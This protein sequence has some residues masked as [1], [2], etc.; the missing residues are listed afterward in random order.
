MLFG[1]YAKSAAEAEYPELWNGLVLSSSPCTAP[2]GGLAVQ[3][4]V[5]RR[6]GTFLNITESR[7]NSVGKYRGVRF[8]VGG[9]REAVTCS[10]ASI[11]AG[12]MS[13]AAWIYATSY[14]ST[15][16]SSI[17]YDYNAYG[18]VGQTSFG[19]QFRESAPLSGYL[20]AAVYQTPVKII[21]ATATSHEIALNTVS[22]A[23]M[24]WS[25]GTTGSSI[26]VV[27][28]GM[29]AT[30]TPGS[31]GTF[32]GPMGSRAAVAIGN[33][34]ESSTGSAYGFTGTIFEYLQWNRVLSPSQWSTLYALGPGGIF[35]PRR[36]R[37]NYVA[38][39]DINRRRRLLLA[40]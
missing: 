12:V 13:A 8:A 16:G 33:Y 31:Y 20:Q 18:G 37:W 34:L 32:T 7:W 5:F 36:R 4:P 29:I 38:A 23:G 25:G 27:S 9:G 28:N 35:T 1:E 40:S 6:P 11:P 22:L 3:D 24:S 39:S 21:N 19:L 26:N 14:G 2:P 17:A 15:Y 10:S 30:S